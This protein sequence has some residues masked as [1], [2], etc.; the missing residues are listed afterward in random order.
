[1]QRKWSPDA[2]RLIVASLAWGADLIRVG[3]EDATVA[4]E[5]P[6]T[7]PES[8]ADVDPLTCVRGHLLPARLGA[9]TG[10]TIVASDTSS[11]GRA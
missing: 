9:E 8:L 10:K 4:F 11:T 3:A 5:W 7:R 2:V 1:M 6:S